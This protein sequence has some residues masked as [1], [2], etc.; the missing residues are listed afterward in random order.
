VSSAWLQDVPEELTRLLRSWKIPQLL[1]YQRAMSKLDTIGLQ[2][3][4]STDWEPLGKPVARLA[5]SRPSRA[6]VFRSS[7][8]ALCGDRLCAKGGRSEGS[9]SPKHP[10]FPVTCQSEQRATE[11]AGG[12]RGQLS[13]GFVRRIASHRRP[14]RAES[15]RATS[16]LNIRIP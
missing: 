4:H 15:P 2:V 5:R 11:L 10:I 16:Q 6:Y 9:G 3:E 12:Y 1:D 7:F 8:S 14:R 13:S